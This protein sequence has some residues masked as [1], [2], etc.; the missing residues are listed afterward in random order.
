MS[1]RNRS[2]QTLSLRDRLAIWANKLRA[3]AAALPAGPEQD[4]LLGKANQAEATIEIEDWM[5]PQPDQKPLIQMSAEFLQRAKKYREK[6]EEC[7]QF[8]SHAQNETA[9]DSYL[10]VADNYEKAA[11]DVELLASLKLPRDRELADKAERSRSTEVE[12]R[13]P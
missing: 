7:R 10:M 1:K 5:Q 3:K 8:A 2:K 13:Q 4:T 11:N 12:E 9:R 6:A